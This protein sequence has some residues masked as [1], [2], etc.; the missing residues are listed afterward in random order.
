LFDKELVPV[1]VLKA[2][3]LVEPREKLPKA[4]LFVPFVTESS[5]FAPTP[6][7]ETDPGFLIIV[8]QEPSQYC[9]ESVEFKNVSIPALGLVMA[10]FLADS[11][12]KV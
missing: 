11:L 12:V 1:A 3:L 5:E 7:L 10:E 9:K 4:V 6:V 8:F 2:P